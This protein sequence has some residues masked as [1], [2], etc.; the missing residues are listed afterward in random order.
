MNIRVVYQIKLKEQMCPTMQ[1][2]KLLLEINISC[3]YI[4]PKLTSTFQQYS[5]C[6]DKVKC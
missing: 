3:K 4:L 6:K 5:K 1:S 2:V